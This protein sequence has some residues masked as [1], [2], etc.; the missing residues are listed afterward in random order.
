[1]QLTHISQ[2]RHVVPVAKMLHI[3][4]PDVQYKVNI[5][6]N[7]LTG[8]MVLDDYERIMG[9]RERGLLAYNM[10]P[11]GVRRA[12]TRYGWR[13]GEPRPTIT[14]L[15]PFLRNDARMRPR[16]YVPKV[17]ATAV[18]MYRVANGQ[19]LSVL[20]E[21]EPE[22]VPGWNP[23]NDGASWMLTSSD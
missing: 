19:P 3:G 20:E 17:L 18:M 23:A 2:T 22:A 1:M 14:E 21:L 10:G 16:V 13:E 8:V 5:Q 15:R 9:S 12:M 4:T 7:L 6:H 11:G